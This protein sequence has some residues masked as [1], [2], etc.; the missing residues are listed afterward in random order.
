MSLRLGLFL[1]G[2]IFGL[3][4]ILFNKIGV[5]TLVLGFMMIIIYLLFNATLPKE[6]NLWSNIFS[7]YSIKPSSQS[8]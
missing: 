4:E 5:I 2:E 1:L 7:N 6:T 8:E 3:V